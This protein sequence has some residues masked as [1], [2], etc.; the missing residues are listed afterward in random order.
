M[1]RRVNKGVC[2]ITGW[3]FDC[4]G[5]SDMLY[6]LLFPK[7]SLELATDLW[8]VGT[9]NGFELYRSVV[10]KSDPPRRWTTFT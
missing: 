2:H 9:S 1:S 8:Q 7:L 4:A 6:K 3:D 5:K 10:Q